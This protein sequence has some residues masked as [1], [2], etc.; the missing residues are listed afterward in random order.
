PLHTALDQLSAMST[1]DKET[2]GLTAAEVAAGGRIAAPRHWLAL[3]FRRWAAIS[4]ADVAD[5]IAMRRDLAADNGEMHAAAAHRSLC[6]V[7]DLALGVVVDRDCRLRHQG[8]M[9]TSGALIVILSSPSIVI[10]LALIVMS[11]FASTVM[12]RSALTTR[13]PSSF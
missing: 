9:S 3:N 6:A 11:S 10:V 13:S 12:C 1:I 4:D 2:F 8:L 7:E 5:M